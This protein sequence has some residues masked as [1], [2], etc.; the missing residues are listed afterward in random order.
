[1]TDVSFGGL[2]VV[3]VIALA[4]PL[5]V[6]LAPR[7]RIPADVVAIVAGIVVGPSVLG[8]VTLDIPIGVLAL[9]GLAFLLF[10]AGAELDLD[11]LR[12]P[13]LRLV[14]MGFLASVAI[15][16]LAG[17]AFHAAGYISSPFLLAVALSATS[18]G[19]VVP[20]LKDAGQ[21]ERELGQLVVAAASVADFG[22][23]LLL[24]FF[25]SS[26]SSGPAVK[27]VLLAGLVLLVAVVAAALARVNMSMGVSGLLTRLQDTTAEIR[28][29]IA[30]VLLVAFVAVA[31]WI[32]LEAILGAFLAGA[33]LA[34]TDREAMTH[35]HFR[36][37]LE[38]IGY[39]FLVPV[40]FV[41][42]GIRFDLQALT[43]NPSAFLRVPLFLLALLVVRGLPA[44]LY[45]RR[46]GRRG[47]IAAGL[48]QATSLPFLVTA[49]QI[50]LSTGTLSAAT[51][52]ALIFAGLLSV[53]L[54][55]VSA[56][57]ILGR[58]PAAAPTPD[59]SAPSAG[60]VAGVVAGGTSPGRPSGQAAES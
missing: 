6:N 32:G 12:G 13:L 18:L 35:P 41:A 27:L 52:A 23:I 3:A 36:A 55:P 48:L 43:S 17:L 39:G 45:L 34:A 37:K 38:A 33:I 28:V 58:Q 25:F 19:L 26:S 5:L 11:R 24:S 14:G 56:L 29:R 42:S 50:G 57:A 16:V 4:A 21:L 7:A 30:I 60:V 54:F 10:L 40:F 31:Q 51:G 22:A 49:V 46:V 59:Q 8:W 2:L 15:G 1:M 44:G 9:L 47:T 20:I 53:V